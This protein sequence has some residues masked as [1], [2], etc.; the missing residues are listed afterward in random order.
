MA[1][2]KQG[3][4]TVNVKLAT[5]GKLFLVD[6]PITAT[7]RELQAAV[8]VCQ[9]AVPQPCNADVWSPLCLHTGEAGQAAEAAVQRTANG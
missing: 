3:Q 2:N 9:N 5:T 4:I 1:E 6:V 7:G 8:Q